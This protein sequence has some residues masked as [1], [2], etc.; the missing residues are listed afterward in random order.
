MPQRSGEQEETD[1]HYDPPMID[2]DEVQ[3][4]YTHYECDGCTCCSA[5]GCNRTVHSQCPRDGLGD[6]LCPCTEES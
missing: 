1:M 2:P 6:L 4:R 5:D 3:W